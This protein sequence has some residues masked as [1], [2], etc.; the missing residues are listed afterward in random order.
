MQEQ[1]LIT[2]GFNLMLLGMGFV[3]TF[4]TVL[5]I[6]TTLMSKIINRFFPQA[7]P[8]PSS[9]AR[10]AAGHVAQGQQPEVIAAISAALRLHRQRR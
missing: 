8:T 5:V 9:A 10:P 7:A 2:E 3:F 4:L 1:N 6:A